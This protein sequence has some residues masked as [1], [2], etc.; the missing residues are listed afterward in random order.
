VI[1]ELLDELHG[2][3][4]FSK[5]DLRSGYHQIRVHPR[6]VQKT[7]FRT[8]EGHYEFLVM[9]F[10][11]T[12]APSTFQGLM[13]EVFKPFLRRFVLVFF[14]D[15]LVYS[16]TLNDHLAHLREVLAVLKNHTLY[17]KQ[18][19]CKFGVPQIDYLGHL[20]SCEGVKAD[21]SKLESMAAWPLPRNIKSLRG[22]LGLTGYYR[23]FIRGY[24]IIAAPLT[25][26]LKKNAF[27][28]T[29]LATEAF[30][31][32]KQAVIS[33]PVLRLPDFTK[34]FTI[35]CDACGS[36]IGAVLMQEGQPIAF[37]SQ[38]LKGRALFL[39]TYEKELLSL[40]TSVQKWRPYLLGQPF[41]VR[42]DQQSLKFLLEQKVGTISQQRWVSKLLGYD[43]T[44]EYKRGKDNR[45]ADALSRQFE[46]N[47][48]AEYA[49]IS[50]I[51]FP[52]PD[53]TVELKQSYLQDPA[54]QTLLTKLQTGDHPPKGYSLQQGLILRKGKIYVV[55]D[56]SFKQQVL[57][58]IHSNPTAGHSGYH[59]TVQRAKTDFYWSGMRKDIKKLVRECTVCQENKNE[60][61]P[62]PG[63]LQPLP[64]P[65][66]VWTDI[67][68]DFIEGLPKSHGYTVILVVIDRLSKYGHFIPLSHPYTAST[69]AH[70]FL[71]NV[72]KLHGM[73]KTI[74]SDRDPIF[75]S[76]F[77][78]QLF[79][80]Q[81]ITLALSSAY[82]P[83]SDGQTEAL[84]KC[85]EGYLRCFSGT[86]PKDWSTWL[87]MAEWWYN[88]NHHSSTHTTPFEV[89][90]GFPP[91]TLLS[92][93]PG[94]T[95]NLAVDTHLRDR[96]KIISTLKEHLLMAQHRMKSQAD[97]HRTEREF[98]VGDWVYL[99]LQ[100]YRQKTV[101][102]RRNLKLSPRFFGPFQILSRIGSVAYRLNL[103]PEAR[104]HPVFH[105]SCL[106]KKLGQ[107]ITPIPTL[108]PVDGNGEIQP[109][110]EAIIDRRMVRQ[111]SRASSEV[112][113]KWVGAP[114][115]D[116]TWESLYKLRNL[117]P[118]LVGKVL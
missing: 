113:I 4:I 104:I 69:V 15:I 7:A 97:K 32:L 17:A 91:P 65:T 105:V 96:N 84:N 25:K 66:Q 58:F 111:G 102:M 27:Q 92:Y 99:R 80:L 53:W 39:S 45:V 26:L 21:P 95:A 59:K 54:T 74:V 94:T 81:G 51:S 67:S 56:S 79:H 30:N 52:T 90:Y 13:N 23:K 40:V 77:W 28:W 109:E 68:L 37:F 38:A 71:T 101:A 24:G 110:P 93:V 75:T 49:T 85:L 100:P 57:E 47:S 107:Q 16:K 35:E 5:L 43:F 34:P 73:P 18:S 82:H 61:I 62:S 36:G 83:Q 60:L 9:P 118:H 48:L 115:E 108:P 12:N 6:D 19:K 50:L 87:P 10:G 63:L 76:S 41:K 33:P 29:A 14:D 55:K 42:T 11:L 72:L 31:Q 88:T 98:E 116:N 2:A 44:I 103:P 22:F 106:K 70:L 46:D 117:Y 8:H 64:I 3:Q 114:A 20:I 86:K 78:Q 112:L 1:D 89:L